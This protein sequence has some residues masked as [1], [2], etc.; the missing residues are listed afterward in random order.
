MYKRSNCM[1]QDSSGWERDNRGEISCWKSVTSRVKK[2]EKGVFFKLY[3]L[4]Q[5]FGYVK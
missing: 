4:I 5:E 1:V 3:L 2:S